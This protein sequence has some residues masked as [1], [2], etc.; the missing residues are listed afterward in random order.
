MEPNPSLC[1]YPNKPCMNARSSKKNGSLHNLCEY[2]REKANAMQQLYV[3][4][5]KSLDQRSP[6]TRPKDVLAYCELIEKAKVL[7]R[8]ASLDLEP[9]AF[10][11]N[12]ATEELP[13]LSQIDFDILLTSM[14]LTEDSAEFEMLG[15]PSTWSSH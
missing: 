4:K 14:E 8:S 15:S 3:L 11:A 6:S 10:A 12:G 5:R 2:H 1:K 13:P 7:Q 9:I